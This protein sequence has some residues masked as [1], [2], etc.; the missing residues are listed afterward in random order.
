MST[1]IASTSPNLYITCNI[2]RACDKIHVL[3]SRK[4]LKNIVQ[5][6]PQ[7]FFKLSRDDQNTRRPRQ[8][9]SKFRTMASS[10]SSPSPSSSSSNRSP[11]LLKKW[12]LGVLLSVILPAAGH[13]GGFLLG[14]KVKIDQAMETVENVTEIV[15]EIAEEAEKIAEEVE[16]KLPEDSKLKETL[17]SFE[18]LTKMAAKEARRAQDIVHQLLLNLDARVKEVE[19]EIEEALIKAHK[20]QPPK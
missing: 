12:L 13:K 17:D 1:K 7:Q 2:A 4:C 15:E 10:P 16:E 5:A 3:H 9:S 14:L 20:D 19:E 8:F 18:E 11:S 6:Q